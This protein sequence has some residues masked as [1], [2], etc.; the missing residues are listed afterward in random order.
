MSV[1]LYALRGDTRPGYIST[2]GGGRKCGGKEGAAPSL[3]CGGGKNGRLTPP[4][5][6]RAIQHAARVGGLTQLKHAEGPKSTMLRSALGDAFHHLNSQHV[7][8]KTGWMHLRRPLT[9]RGAKPE[10]GGGR[11]RD[12]ES[13]SGKCSGSFSQKGTR[14]TCQAP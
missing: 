8:P 3:G 14:G 6:P 11:G 13:E 1:F 10:R 2:G 5:Y 9:C 4:N 12:R 7:V